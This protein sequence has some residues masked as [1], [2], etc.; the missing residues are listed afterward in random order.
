MHVVEFFN[1]AW[2]SADA[3]YLHAAGGAFRD[4][5]DFYFY[6]AGC[7][8]FEQVCKMGKDFSAKAP[9]GRVV[10]LV[11]SDFPALHAEKYSFRAGELNNICALRIHRLGWFYP[12]P[13]KGVEQAVT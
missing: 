7:K 2:F 12:L 3:G 13:C 8:V 10:E 4:A 5:E 1:F 11:F 6:A 9:V